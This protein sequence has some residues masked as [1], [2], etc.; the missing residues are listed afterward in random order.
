MSKYWVD[1]PSGW[2]FGFPKVY[3]TECGDIDQWLLDSGYPQKEMDNWKNGVPYRMWAYEEKE[4]V[5]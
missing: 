4:G 3:D 1:P 2:C 5:S